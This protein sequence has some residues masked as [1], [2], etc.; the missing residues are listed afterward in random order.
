MTLDQAKQILEAE[1]ENG[2][3][4]L[5]CGR[6][7]KIYTRQISKRVARCLIGLYSFSI[8]DPRFFHVLEMPETNKRSSGDFTKLA[9]WGLMVERF[10]D[11][12]TKQTSGFWK[13]TQKGIDFVEGKILL[14][15]YVRTFDNK[16]LGYVGGNVSIHDCLKERFDFSVLMSTKKFEEITVDDF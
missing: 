9:L 2:C 16:I 1:K 8:D 11:D 5:C 10:N 4:C 6:W 12:D 15:K 7:A 3:F 14:P 13:I